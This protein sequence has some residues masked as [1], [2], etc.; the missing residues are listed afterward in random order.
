MPSSLPHPAHPQPPE[1]WEGGGGSWQSCTTLGL[2]PS[3][4]KAEELLHRPGGLRHGDRW[5]VP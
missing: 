4:R 3:D 2:V 5:L 1:V